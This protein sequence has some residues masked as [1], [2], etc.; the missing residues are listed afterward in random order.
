MGDPMGVHT[1]QAGFGESSEKDRERDAHVRA[2]SKSCYLSQRHSHESRKSGF[3]H[4]EW[5]ADTRA[6]PRGSC[7]T[8]SHAQLPRI[9]QVLHLSVSSLGLC[10]PTR[11]SFSIARCS[12][13]VHVMVEHDS[14]LTRLTIDRYGSS[15]LSSKR[16]GWYFRI[17][18]DWLFGLPSKHYYKLR[19]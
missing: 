18:S 8:A 4:M 7:T 13:H 3:A 11:M 16:H 15:F 9:S 10:L 19:T 1:G 2:R 5:L 6:T 14:R 17:I 12:A